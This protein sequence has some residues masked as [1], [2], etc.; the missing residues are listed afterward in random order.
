VASSIHPASDGGKRVVATPYAKQLA[1]QFNVDL[2][3]IVNV[4]SD[5]LNEKSLEKKVNPRDGGKQ[6]FVIGSTPS[7]L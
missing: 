4:A 2:A 6:V 3:S 5:I 7:S 1:K